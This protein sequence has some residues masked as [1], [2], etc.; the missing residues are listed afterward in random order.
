M[1]H[2]LLTTAPQSVELCMRLRAIRYAD[3]DSVRSQVFAEAA[4]RAA[5]V[6]QCLHQFIFDSNEDPQK[7]FDG[8]RNV[9]QT[10]E[11]AWRAVT[12]KN[13]KAM[14]FCKQLDDQWLP[15]VSMR[16]SMSAL[17]RVKAN[18]RNMTNVPRLV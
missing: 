16:S 6:D 10:S 15:F 8:S 9:L 18:C 7:I 12:A 17:L 11:A 13:E 2:P 3:L 4:A 1:P 5:I 14:K